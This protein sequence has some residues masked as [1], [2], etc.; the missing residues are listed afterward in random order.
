MS[1]D[2]SMDITTDEVSFS[3]YDSCDCRAI[4]YKVHQYGL[5]KARSTCGLRSYAVHV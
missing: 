4:G 3:D 2:F 5:R 1:S